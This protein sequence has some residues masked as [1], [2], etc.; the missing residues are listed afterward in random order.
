MNQSPCHRNGLRS[1]LLTVFLLQLVGDP[2]FFVSREKPRLCGSVRQQETRQK[3]ARYRRQS[4]QNEQP[5]PTAKTKPMH[6]IENETRNGT[7][8]DAGE[9][10]ANQYDSNGLR[11]FALAE[12]ITQV[13]NDAGEISCFGE[14]KRKAGGIE[15]MGR[16]HKAC[17]R[18]NDA[19][20][21]NRK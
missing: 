6:V 4:F 18:R 2:S 16:L 11:L 14:A 20:I 10:H 15:L 7:A 19:G 9:R 13:E 8:Q 3:H 1:R 17:Q 21:S 12:P 5:S